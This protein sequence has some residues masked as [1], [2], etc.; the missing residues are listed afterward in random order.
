MISK[1]NLKD[2]YPLSLMQEGMLFHAL[3]ET[4]STAYFEQTSYLIKGNLDIEIFKYSLNELFKRHDVLRTVIVHKKVARPLQVVLK[5]LEAAFYFE[6]LRQ[7]SPE[8][9]KK[10]IS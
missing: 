7:Q 6:D 2:L 9:Q 8:E 5:E 3:L 1:K 10:A 4:Q